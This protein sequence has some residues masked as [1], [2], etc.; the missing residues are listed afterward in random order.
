MNAVVLDFAQQLGA[1]HA[2]LSSLLAPHALQRG[3]AG[4][5]LA[6]FHAATLASA[7]Q[8]IVRVADREAVAA[9]AYVRVAG[10]PAPQLSPWQ[11]FALAGETTDV[12][13]L[14]RLCRALHVANF[15]AGF[16]RGE[17]LFLNVHPE[18]PELVKSDFGL[19]FRR[20]ITLLGEVPEHTVLELRFDAAAAPGLVRDVIRGWR[21]RGFGVALDL[22]L[23]PS[24]TTLAAVAA[25][26]VLPDFIKFTPSTE[27]DLA[28]GALRQWRQQGVV[29]VGTRLGD[30]GSVA[31]AVAAGANCLQGRAIDAATGNARA[32]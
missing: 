20:L 31:L 16:A 26:G 9:E 23:G 12:V 29:L 21:A 3:A 19:S 5:T 4:E 8:P 22:G 7:F 24:R 6:H 27:I 15:S 28:F 32:A 17:R 18:L 10:G 30:A 25:L 1:A 14:D 11:L 13:R 2:A